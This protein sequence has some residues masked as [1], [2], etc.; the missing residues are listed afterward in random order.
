MFDPGIFHFGGILFVRILSQTQHM[1]IE[2]VDKSNSDCNIKAIF[3]P[4]WQCIVE[5]LYAIIIM[6]KQGV[7][8]SHR[9]MMIK[10]IKE[11]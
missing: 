5:F 2:Q 9:A 4:G 3:P 6:I 10:V 8:D 11:E 1:K 7:L